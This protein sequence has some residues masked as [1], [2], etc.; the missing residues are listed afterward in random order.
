MGGDKL[1]DCCNSVFFFWELRD[2]NVGVWGVSSSFA[3][4]FELRIRDFVFFW[5]SVKRS[6]LASVLGSFFV[7]YA[8]SISCWCRSF[9][10]KFVSFLMS[11]PPLQILEI[12]IDGDQD[13]G[14]V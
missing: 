4:E 10:H 8:K 2:D 9:D 3:S 7:K 5:R 1:G 12:E 11:T 14:I 13:R 6:P